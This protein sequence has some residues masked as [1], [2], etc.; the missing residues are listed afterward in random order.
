MADYSSASPEEQQR[1]MVQRMI[2]QQH[3]AMPCKILSFDGK[4]ASVQP[5]TQMKLTQGEQVSY[6][7]LPVVEG[8]PVI[9]PYAQTLGLALTLPIKPGD[10]GLLIVPDRGIDNFKASSGASPTAPPFGGDPQTSAA[11]AHSLTDGILIPGCSVDAAAL[12]QYD[13]EHI[14]V[15]DKERKI[16][17]SLGNDG[18]KI[19]DGQATITMQEGA[20]NLETPGSFNVQCGGAITMTSTNLNIGEDAS[21]MTSTL[22]STNGTFID[23]DGVVLNTHTHKGVQTGT[24]TTDEP[25]K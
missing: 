21:S 12:P 3:V 19:T 22:T 10:T 1:A 14:E 18:I 23:K 25:A 7:S 20:V 4:T 6:K 17:I 13:L 5:L 8:V 9:L 11:R 2:D 16:F 24:D 15:R